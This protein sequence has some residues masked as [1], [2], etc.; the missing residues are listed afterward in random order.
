MRH[1]KDDLV[2]NAASLKLWEENDELF[3]KEMLKFKEIKVPDKFELSF[4]DDGKAVESEQVVLHPSTVVAQHDDAGL[5]IR[6]AANVQMGSFNENLPQSNP[7]VNLGQKISATHKHAAHS[8]QGDQR[9]VFAGNEVINENSA[10]AQNTYTNISNKNQD[11]YFEDEIDKEEQKS[12]I[13]TEGTIQPIDENVIICDNE[14][15]NFFGNQ[16]LKFE[17]LDKFSVMTQEEF[18]SRSAGS[19]SQEV[20]KEDEDGLIHGQESIVN[21]AYKPQKDIRADRTEKAPV[22]GR[23]YDDKHYAADQQELGEKT[24]VQQ[25]ERA[26]MEYKNA[27]GVSFGDI[28]G[29]KHSNNEQIVLLD[30]KSSSVKSTEVYD[31]VDQEFDDLSAT[32]PSQVSRDSCNDEQGNTSKYSFLEES[33][34]SLGV[35]EDANI[36]NMPTLNEGDMSSGSVFEGSCVKNRFEDAVEESAAAD[37]TQIGEFSNIGTVLQF[38]KRTLRKESDDHK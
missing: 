3:A 5:N 15:F 2:K 11:F 19:V 25:L 21:E 13:N 31:Q 30:E 12:E 16:D 6:E 35:T 10:N 4:E 17:N 29:D 7:A 8:T 14:H 20:I 24:I 1:G 32:M 34:N 23:K 18:L 22:Q 9:F 27:N 33:F 26:N 38:N 36:V 28:N 37:K